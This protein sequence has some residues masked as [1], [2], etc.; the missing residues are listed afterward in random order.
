MPS[1]DPNFKP[2]DLNDILDDE[3]D[4]EYMGK[5]RKIVMS[6]GNFVWIECRDPY[7]FWYISLEKGKLP[8]K[9]TGSYTTFDMALRDVNQ[10]LRDKKEP[11]V[12]ETNV[13]KKKIEYKPVEV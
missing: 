9:L 12:Y 8:D 1:V 3:L 10:W 2:L 11:I 13:P 6:N 4:K 7:G 5:L